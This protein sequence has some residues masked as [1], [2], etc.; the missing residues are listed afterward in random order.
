M[1]VINEGKKG[2]GTLEVLRIFIV[3]EVREVATIVKDHV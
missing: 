1:S 2:H 3:D